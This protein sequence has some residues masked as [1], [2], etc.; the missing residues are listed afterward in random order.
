SLEKVPRIWGLSAKEVL[1]DSREGPENLGSRRS[2][3]SKIMNASNN[4]HWVAS[5]LLFSFQLRSSH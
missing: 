1:R 4:D 2:W 5:I 3:R